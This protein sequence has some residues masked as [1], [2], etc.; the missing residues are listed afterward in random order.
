M[1]QF[2]FVDE[3]REKRE[4]GD[5]CV[6]SN[7]FDQRAGAVVKKSPKPNAWVCNVGGEM[8]TVFEFEEAWKEQDAQKDPAQGL[9]G[10]GRDKTQRP[11]RQEVSKVS[12]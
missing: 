8:L 5:V 11:E 10:N 1:I 6:I 4:P 7:G 12:D 2:V 9:Q 3:Y